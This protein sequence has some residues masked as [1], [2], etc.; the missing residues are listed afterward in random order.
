M[1]R[2]ICIILALIMLLIP[3]SVFADDGAAKTE[4]IKLSYED[5]YNKMK[6]SDTWT[7]LQLNNKADRASLE[8]IRQKTKNKTGGIEDKDAELRYSYAKDIVDLN[9]TARENALNLE[10][11]EKYYSLNYKEDSLKTSQENVAT[12]KRS[13]EIAQKKYKLGTASKSDVLA[14]EIDYNQALNNLTS[15]ENSLADAKMSFNIYLGYDIDQQIELTD[16]A[17]EVALP[18]ITLEE[19][20]N[21]ALTN[22]LDV[23]RDTYLWAAAEM[24]YYHAK[25]TT[26]G[27]SAEGINAYISYTKQK[28][29]HDQA[30]D[31]LKK[32]VRSK[33]NAMH[34]A[35]N[36]LQL[37]KQNVTK[38]EESLTIAQKRYETGL[39]TL[40][41]LT[42]AEN[43]VYSA[44]LSLS[45]CLYNYNLAV[46][47]FNYCYGIGIQA[48]SL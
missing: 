9:V 34:E 43:S 17:E 41:D 40:A 36:A 23:K 26:A 24:D 10:V 22:R 6:E 45:Q 21:L 20:E 47:K 37:Q 8:S 5:A 25:L 14:A 30:E 19:A 7:L 48:V 46:Q 18:E 44:K 29:E 38:A 27:G 33:Y 28:I 3:A 4:L 42:K 16:I 11:F 32:D 12:A 1:K 13:L 15:A 39:N 35:Y 31:T 2:T